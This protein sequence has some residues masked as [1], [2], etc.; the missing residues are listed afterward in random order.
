MPLALKAL[1]HRP[2]RQ[3]STPLHWGG[4]AFVVGDRLVYSKSL[5]TQ[6]VLLVFIIASST[7]W[8]CCC[9]MAITSRSCRIKVWLP[10]VPLESAELSKM[11]LEQFQLM[12][13]DVG[14]VCGCSWLGGLKGRCINSRSSMCDS[15]LKELGQCQTL[16]ILPLVL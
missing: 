9:C 15:N 1:H 10:A 3:L 6:F 11:M 4:V 16:H 8:Y 5:S 12:P 7:S 2:G 14:I 13:S